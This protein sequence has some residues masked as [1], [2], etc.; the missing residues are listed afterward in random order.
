[1]S[2][3]HRRAA[4]VAA[5]LAATASG[6]GAVQAQ[7]AAPTCRTADLSLSVGQVTGGAGSFFHPIRFT[8]TSARS[9]ALRGYPGVSVLDSQ[10]RQ[11]GA[12][13]SAGPHAVTTVLVRPAGSVYAAVRTN[14]PSIVGRCRATSTYLRVY[15]PGN[16]EAVLVPHRLRVCGAFQVNP[17]QS[18]P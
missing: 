10:H 14:D 16:R 11:I 18:T 2:P 3:V 15:P 7:A 17:V 8:N 5:L 13:A 9:C 12:A 1:M 4:V 6:T